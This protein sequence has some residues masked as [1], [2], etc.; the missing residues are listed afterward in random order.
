VHFSSLAVVGS[1][2]QG[3]YAAANAAMDAHAAAARRSGMPS[4][5]VQW[6]AWAGVGMAA[7]TVSAA[8]ELSGAGALQ[9]SQGAACLLTLLMNATSAPSVVVSRFEWTAFLQSGKKNCPGDDSLF[10]EMRLEVEAFAPVSDAVVVSL[11]LQTQSAHS[12]SI[13]IEYI[14]EAIVGMVAPYIGVDDGGGDGFSSEQPLMEAG[15]DS[16]SMTELSAEIASR[17]GGLYKLNP[18]Y[19]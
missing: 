12:V 7:G 19:P 6:G 9:P 17:W 4:M 5:S 15:L 2:G 11:L 8:A 14:G 1:P 18:D 13:S 10:C 3:N 16:L